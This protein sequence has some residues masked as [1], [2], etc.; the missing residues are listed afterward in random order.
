ARVQA[1]EERPLPHGGSRQL[2]GPRLRG[3]KE[4][5]LLAR[6]RAFLRLAVPAPLLAVSPHEKRPARRDEEQRKGHPVASGAA[7]AG[8]ALGPAAASSIGPTASASVGST[9]TTSV[10]SGGRT[11]HQ[12]GSGGCVSC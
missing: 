4:D 8:R 3:R 11:Y 12:D 2:R 7:A 9:S 1:G 6:R 5:P 10:G